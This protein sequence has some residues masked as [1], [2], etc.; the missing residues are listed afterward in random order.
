MFRL[1]TSVCLFTIFCIHCPLVSAAND[2]L[3]DAFAASS[4]DMPMQADP[5]TRKFLQG[6]ASKLKSGRHVQSV[7]PAVVAT[8]DVHSGKAWQ[9]RSFNLR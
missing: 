9:V 5:A 3:G 6:I 4:S 7:S 2:A 8:F 1:I